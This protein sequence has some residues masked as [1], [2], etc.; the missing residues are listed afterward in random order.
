VSGFSGWRNRQYRDLRQ[1]AADAREQRTATRGHIYAL[2][3]PFSVI[4]GC[5]L[6]T[7]VDDRFG[8]APWGFVVFLCA[9]VAAAVRSIVRIIRWQQSLDD[10]DATAAAQTAPDQHLRARGDDAAS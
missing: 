3:I 10:A 4:I 9:G 6:G 1:I 2:E 5:V 8:T 7:V